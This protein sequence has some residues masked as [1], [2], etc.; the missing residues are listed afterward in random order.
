MFKAYINNVCFY[1]DRLEQ[2]TI[3]GLKLKL[4]ENKAG[5]FEFTIY[6]D[7][8]WYSSFEKLV[9]TITV[10][11]NGKIIFR[12]R[13]LDSEESF[14]KER[15]ITCEGEYA[16]FNDAVFYPLGSE[17]VEATSDDEESEPGTKYTPIEIFTQIIT[18]YNSQVPEN[19]RFLV[20][21]ISIPNSTEDMDFWNLEFKTS[22]DALDDLLE[23]CGGHLVFRHEESGIYID[24]TDDYQLIDQRVEFGRNLLDLTQTIQA[25]ELVTAILPYGDSDEN[26]NIPTNISHMQIPTT[27]L[28]VQMGIVPAGPDNSRDEQFGPYGIYLVNIPLYEKYGLIV[29]ERA[30]DGYPADWKN[31]LIADVDGLTGLTN[32]IEVEAVDLAWLENMQFFE[33]GKAVKVQS[34][35]H[36]VND[37]YHITKIDIDLQDPSSSNFTLGKTIK[38]F[39]EQIVDADRKPVD[40]QSIKVTGYEFAYAISNDGIVV[41]DDA[42]F[43]DT[44][45]PQQGKWLWTRVIT[46]FNDGA[47]TKCYYPSYLSI[48]GKVFRIKADNT[49]VV[50]NDRRDDA[51]TIVFSAEISGYPD[52]L[53]LWYVDGQKIGEG[54]SV[55]ISIPYKMAE[56]FSINLYNDTELMDTLNL[57]VIDETGGAVYLGPCSEA[58]PTQTPDGL[59]LITGDYFLATG[60]FDSYV[61]GNPYVWDGTTFVSISR[62]HNVTDDEWARI[63]NGCLDDAV[64]NSQDVD[65]RFFNWFRTLATKEG[66]FRFLTVYRLLIG[67]GTPTSGL[68]FMI[69]SVDENGDPLSVPIFKCLYD[70]VNM[71]TIDLSSLSVIIGDYYNTGGMIWDAKAKQ[72]TLRGTGTF[73]GTLDTVTIKTEKGNGSTKYD[74][75]NI[76]D[77]TQLGSFIYPLLTPNILATASGNVNGKQISSISRG[78]TSRVE[79]RWGES[80]RDGMER[81]YNA[82]TQIGY[83]IEIYINLSDGTSLTY[84]CCKAGQTSHTRSD[85]NYDWPTPID[86]EYS[87]EEILGSSDEL[88]TSGYFDV[89]TDAVPS[90]F[91]YS[92]PLLSIYDQTSERLFIHNLPRQAPTEQYRVW[93][94]PEGC[95]RLTT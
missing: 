7:N 51:Q 87:D 82:Y 42:S 73:Q 39:V 29:E 20:G 83:Y 5:S 62:G 94:D 22:I 89:Q 43:S 50:R 32:S 81:T 84:R 92:I 38:N 3:T 65:T 53:P 21:N 24:W 17:P 88:G 95:L 46:T 40:V 68:Y 79:S 28:H 90:L 52:A 44:Y 8:P 55:S 59:A 13:V 64:A 61:N 26:R 18:D 47:S 15:K 91:P 60:T 41:P 85:G 14:I 57:V 4:E 33:L 80:H 34:R 45:T 54:G 67:N 86:P 93:V 72:L 35:H 19:R 71:F 75:S 69:A 30:Y 16:F 31:Q 70:G 76:T 9:S 12:G 48:D 74:K 6:P 37:E 23:E 49:V 25:D 2:N 36:G 27:D 10:E 77:V 66:F 1:D 63:M 78:L 58:I 11:Q 56:A